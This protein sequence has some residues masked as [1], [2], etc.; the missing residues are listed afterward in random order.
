MVAVVLEVVSL[1]AYTRLTQVLL[2]PPNRLG[3]GTQWRIDVVGFGLSH[4]LPGGGATAGG[5]RVGLMT[6]RGVDA[7]AALALTVVQVVLSALGLLSL[8]LLGALMSVPR[9]GM[10]ATTL[11]LLV[12]TA[13]AVVALEV[14]PRLHRTAA[15]RTT[16]RL[17]AAVRGV[18]PHRW[19]YLVRSAVARG[20]T[21]LRDTRVTRKGVTWAAVNWLLDA[22]CLWVCLRAFGASVPIELVLASYSLVNA[23]AM[24]PLT[25]GGI[26]IVEG[27][28]VPALV[29]AGATAEEALFGVLTWRLLQYWLPIPAA[30]ACWVSLTGAE[31]WRR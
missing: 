21:S 6:E 3:F 2:E 20:S 15:R 30:G 18:L 24:L 31:P 14:M 25:P 11:V 28:L 27:L 7:S 1:A 12:A 19:W 10:T 4:A 9:T 5:L 22:V 29:A 26:G 8:W 16:G 23:I 13:S 17:S